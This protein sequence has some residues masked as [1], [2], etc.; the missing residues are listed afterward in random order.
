MKS[1]PPVHLVIA[2]SLADKNQYMSLGVDASINDGAKH[3]CAFTGVPVVIFNGEA[4]TTQ[5]DYSYGTRYSNDTVQNW[6]HTCSGAASS[7]MVRVRA[8]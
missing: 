3:Q 5:C 6:D 7:E 4:G 8:W 2:L 1:F